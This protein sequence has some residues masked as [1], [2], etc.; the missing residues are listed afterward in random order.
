MSYVALFDKDIISEQFG[1]EKLLD[2]LLDEGN[3]RIESSEV[4]ITKKSIILRENEV[5]DYMYILKSG[6]CGAWK[7]KHITIFLG[8]HDIIGMNNILANEQSTLTVTALTDVNA[9][10]FSKEEVLKKL[11]NTQEGIFYLYNDVR[12]ANKDLL[13]KNVLEME[14]TEIRLLCSLLQLGKLYGSENRNIV[15]LP[16]IFTKKIISNYLNI[17]ETTM[18]IICKQLVD[19]GVL[20]SGQPICINKNVAMDRIG[21]ERLLY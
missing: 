7:D 8:G 17:T 2:L 14:D 1:S 13:N 16:K 20:I 12:L 18:Y 15:K 11:M 3:Y 9:W 19:A 10:K 5:H 21:M 6:I 4:R